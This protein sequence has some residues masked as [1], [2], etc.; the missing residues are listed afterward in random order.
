IPEVAK[1]EDF[2]K[3][4]KN[5]VVLATDLDELEN[6]NALDVL[7]KIAMIIIEPKVR[8]VNVRPKNTNLDFQSSMG[9]NALLSI[10]RPE[11]DAERA[12]VFSGNVMSGINFYLNEHDDTGLLAMIARDTGQL[13]QKHF[14]REMATHTQ[15]PLLI[16]HDVKA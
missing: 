16:L 9:R 5:R 3:K 1:F 13:I 2:L 11:I 6:M 12:T 7:K 8:V 14:T 15:F 4:G 10:F